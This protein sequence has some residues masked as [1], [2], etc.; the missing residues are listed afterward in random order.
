M[1]HHDKFEPPNCI[2]ATTDQGMHSACPSKFKKNFSNWPPAAI[3]MSLSW[4]EI[5][6]RDNYLQTDWCAGKEKAST[7]IIKMHIWRYCAK[8]K[9]PHR[10]WICTRICVRLTS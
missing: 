5:I 6:C 2:T 10:F 7:S 3:V 8:S 9:D 1:S 4:V